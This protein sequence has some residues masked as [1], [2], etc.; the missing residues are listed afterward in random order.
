MSLYCGYTTDIAHRL[1]AHAGKIPGGAKYTKSH[2]PLKI[3]KLWSA[4][5]KENAMRLE[6]YFKRL[7]K[8]KKE[9]LISGDISL[10]D[11]LGNKLSEDDFADREESAPE[12]ADIFE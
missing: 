2:R 4:G 7:P 9:M 3:E 6:F 8:E 10:S 12:I 1:K 11:A 5:T